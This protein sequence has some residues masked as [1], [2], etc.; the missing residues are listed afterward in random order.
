MDVSVTVAV[1]VQQGRHT[2]LIPDE[3]YQ[4]AAAAGNDKVN[5]FG[6]LQECGDS[7]A[8]TGIHE[9]YAGSWQIGSFEAFNHAGN[10]DAG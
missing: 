1:E 7:G 3:L 4:A 5:A 9:L 6:A 10:N 2:G 8:I